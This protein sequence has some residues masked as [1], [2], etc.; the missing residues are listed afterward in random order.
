MAKLNNTQIQTIVNEVYSQMTGTSDITDINLSNF[1]DTGLAEIGAN[2]ERFTNALI[3]VLTRNWFSD[4]SYRSEYIDLFYEDAERFG[5]IIQSISVEVPKAKENSAWKDFETEETKV[6][7]YTIHLPKVSTIYFNKSTSWAIP[8]TISWE[9]WDTAF[10]NDG[11]L[12]GFID[13][14]FLMVDNALV[15]HM[16]QL[17]ETNRN[18][19]IAEKILYSQTEDAKGVHVVDLVGLYANEK[20][21]TDSFTVKQALVDREFLAFA[22]ARMEEYIKYFKRQ[23]SMFNTQQKTRFT[24]SDRIVMQVLDK[25]EQN[26]KNIGYANTFNDEY[27]KLPLHQSVAW[28]QNGGNLTFDDVSSIHVTTKNGTVERSGIVGL[29]CDKWAIVHTIRSERVGSQNFN[30]ENITHYEYQHR[31]SYINNLTMNA[32]V[33]VMNDYTAG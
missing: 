9:Q 5:A 26:M 18:N 25:F 4:T 20:G 17:N 28:W 19:F 2:R 12:R 23:T 32:V 11:E 27:I 24:P 31:D 7:E 3:G 1:S 14:V 22:S 16:E 15:A 30:I 8:I 6:G 21:L 29:L 33:F 10:R 13:Y